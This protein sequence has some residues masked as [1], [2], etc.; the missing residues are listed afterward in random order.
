M[1]L[2]GIKQKWLE[3]VRAANEKGIPLPLLKIDGRPT[4][5]GTLT[6]IAF[7]VWILSVVGKAAGALGGMNP[8]QCL[9]MFL[10]C[11][12]LYWGRK[13]QKDDKKSDLGDKIEKAE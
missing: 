12:G 11:A 8:D 1:D 13:F 2:E 4:F 7:N 10:A 5:S 6:F 9:N 3:I